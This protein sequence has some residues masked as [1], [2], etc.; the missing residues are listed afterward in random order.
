[1]FWILL[2]TR[3]NPWIIIIHNKLSKPKQNLIDEIT[4]SVENLFGL[5]KENLFLQACELA[6]QLILY[7]I[8]CT[9]NGNQ[10]LRRTNFFPL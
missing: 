3:V 2:F 6:L 4:Q 10:F 7:K 1:M 8:T 9:C 5:T